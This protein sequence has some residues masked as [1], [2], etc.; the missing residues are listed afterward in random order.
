MTNF[1]NRHSGTI[2]SADEGTAAARRLVRLA[3][4][5]EPV[6]EEPERVTD[7]D[8]YHTGGGWY[9]LP[10]GSKVRGR[11]AAHSALTEGG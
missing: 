11:A 7:V 6:N 1:R 4:L 8:E 10:D 3:R 2:V 9:E 5:W